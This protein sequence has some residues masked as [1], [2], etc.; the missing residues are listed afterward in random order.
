M[1]GVVDLFL[2]AEGFKDRS[3]AIVEFNAVAGAPGDLAHHL[4]H[5]IDRRL[6]VAD[7]LVN[8]VGQ[9]ITHRAVHQIR[10]FKDAAGRGLGLDELLDFGPLL[11]EETHIAHKIPGALAFPNGANNHPDAFRDFQL[12]QDFPEPF[13]FLWVLDL[14]RDA[15]AIAVGHEDQIT[16][17][18]AEVRR[19]A[20][21]FCSDRALS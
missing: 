12:A 14:S 5:S 17:G 9:K 19:H 6:I 15:A 13:P 10:L 3:A 2:D 4:I 7:H 11:D 16:P 8:F 21:A 20:R 1:K 18:E